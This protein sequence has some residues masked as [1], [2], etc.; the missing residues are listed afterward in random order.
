MQ[1]LFPPEDVSDRSV[2]GITQVGNRSKL[3]GTFALVRTIKEHKGLILLLACVGQFMVILDV[4]IVNVALPDMKSSLGFT[5]SELQWVLNAYT[6]SFAGLLL[7]GGRIADIFGR[8]KVFMIGLGVFTLASM[9]GAVSTDRSVLIFARAVQGLGAA[10]LSPATLTIITTTFSEGKERAKALGVWSAVAGAGGAAGALLGG[11]LTDLLN[12]RWIFL[13]NIPI[14]VGAAFLTFLYLSELKR[15]SDKKVALDVLGSVLITFSVTALV[16]ALVEGGSFGWTNSRTLLSFS[17]SG[18]SLVYFLIHEGKVATNPIVPLG[19]LR[20]RQLSVSNITMFFVGGSV[21][22]SWYFLSLFMQQIL[23]YS[24]LKAGLAFVPQ[25]LAIVVGAQISSRL[26]GKI[27]VRPLIVVGPIISAVG[28]MLFHGISIHSTYLGSLFLPSVLTTLGV[29]LAF[30]PLAVAATSGV[31][32][33]QAGLASGLLNTARQ[34]GGAVGLAGLSSVALSFTTSD[35]KTLIAQGRYGLHEAALVAAS[36]GY[37]RSMEI[38]AVIALVA[39][40]FGATLG[41]RQ[42]R[43]ANSSDEAMAVDT[44]LGIEGV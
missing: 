29:G 4:S 20:L 39:A 18:A 26:V 38:S 42:R 1:V 28:L 37:A 11:V 7:L 34:L 13:I 21:F 33:S 16:Y 35:T 30:T 32:R 36:A 43:M 8:R 9:L 41:G 31:H 44:N 22:A 23:G 27:G 12:W 2:L 19:L 6:L 10:I 24:P 14:G 5:D 40:T 17:L 3:R 25:T 15:K